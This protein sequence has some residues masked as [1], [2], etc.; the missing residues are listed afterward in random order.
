[1]K[2]VA[3]MKILYN[4]VLYSPLI[5]NNLEDIPPPNIIDKAFKANLLS[6]FTLNPSTPKQ[7]ETALILVF[8]SNY[9]NA[10]YTLVL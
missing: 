3:E 8:Q 7:Y 1:M 2:I 6:S 10:I 4:K 5:L 9:Q